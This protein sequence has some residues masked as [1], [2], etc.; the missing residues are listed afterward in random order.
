MFTKIVRTSVVAAAALACFGN[1]QAKADA[2]P[3]LFNTGVDTSGTVM[4]HGT[5][6]DPHYSL[7]S[8]PGGTS[9]VRII[10]SAGGWPVGP[11]FGDN[12]TSRWIGPNNDSDLTGPQGNYIYRTLFD[13][14]GYDASS[15]NII[16]GWSTDNDG[17]DILI[18]G[19]STG[20]STAFDQF[21]TGFA[22]FEISSG[23]IA[24]MNTLD[25]VVYNK[26]LPTALRVEM[27]GTANIAPGV[28]EPGTWAMLAGSGLAGAM[29]LI[30]RRRA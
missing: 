6:G 25:F 14:T 5:V 15:A 16:G 19:I 20:H 11:Y 26:S 4:A 17:L 24:G 22:P 3:G 28:P 9:D 23:F 7:M 21:R 10:T 27:A 29:L 8:V 2:I 13:L 18:N 30:R 1:I 12:T